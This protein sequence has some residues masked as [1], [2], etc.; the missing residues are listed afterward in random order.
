MME[1]VSGQVEQVWIELVE[2]T[3]IE[4]TEQVWIELV[5]QIEQTEQSSTD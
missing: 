4:Q 5:E 3:W 2:Q 1:L